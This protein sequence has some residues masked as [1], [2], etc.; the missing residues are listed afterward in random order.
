[1]LDHEHGIAVLHQPVQH[2]QQ[3]LHVRK[4][5]PGGRL[6]QQV[7]R[8][9]RGPLGQLAAQLHALRLAPGQRR[10]GL[11]Q[12]DV[13]QPHVRQR[14]Q[15]PGDGRDML[16]ELQGLSHGHVQ[17][18]R[19]R[20]ALVPDVQGFP[21]VPPALTHLAGHVHVRQKMHFDLDQPSALARLAP[22]ALHV[23]TVTSGPIPAH[24][25]LRQ[26]GEQVPDKREHA[27]VRGGIG[28]RRPADRRLVDVDHLVQGIDALERA[29]TLHARFP[30]I[31]QRRQR[32]EQDLQHQRTLAGPR[33]AGDAGQQPQ[34]KLRVHRFQIMLAGA[35]DREKP[36]GPPRARGQRHPFLPA[37]ILP[38]QR[39]GMPHDVR[40]R[41]LR[42]DGPAVHAGAGPHVH[43]M[44]RHAHGRGVVLH[45][46]HG[47]AQIA[48]PQQGLQQPVIIALVQADT[49]LVQD[50]QHPH[51]PGPDLGRQPDALPFPARE[52]R[53]RPVQRQIIQPHVQQKLQPLP[54]LLQDAL[55]DHPL[56]FVQ[57]QTLEE[58]PG[59][60][61]RELRD[62][63][64]GF[65]AHLH[66][67]AFRLQPRPPAHRAQ[68][69]FGILLPLRARGHLVADAVTRGTRAVRAV[70]RKHPRR[71]FRITHPA[72]DTGQLLTVE[73]DRVLVRQHPDQALGQF[74]R[75]FHRIRQPP[76][77]RL[78]ILH[79]QAVHHDL[80]RMLALLIQRDGLVQSDDRAVDAGAHV[81]RAAGVGQFLAILPLAAAHDRRQHLKPRAHGQRADGI[82]HLLH[83][84]RRNRL[85]AIHAKRL[86]HPGEQQAQVIIN[87]RDGP[88]RGPGIVTGRLL[89]DGDGGREALDGIHVGLAHLFQELARVGRQRLHV[90]PLP[91]GINR[92]EIQR[93]LA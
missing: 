48:Q 71:Q 52:G 67:Q 53:G 59:L 40:G 87:L 69:V 68:V 14:L 42:H 83:G 23:E 54:D 15:L 21:I 29:A 17:H 7:Q 5:Q 12:L 39:V 8:A 18:V 41:P 31:Q 45:D 43:D 24:A 11:P 56:A 60:A 47:I 78:F 32:R 72:R 37:Q 10:R 66:R 19:D 88:D 65:V 63:G 70:E 51:Q 80:D 25:R 58:R 64:D 6:V 26:P 50:I 90:A 46:Q 16:E 13:V 91:L 4:M 28:A 86:A 76:L 75:R 85:P 27:S 84:L 49:R 92:V 3:A 9:A 20:L 34:W 57:V 79:H 77:Q 2:V 82:H 55:A 1:M 22:A 44:I 81:P 74:Q 35:H 36:L 33:H 61:D 38:G 73:R 89:L 30:V 93:R 62:L